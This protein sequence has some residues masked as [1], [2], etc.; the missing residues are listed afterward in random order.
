MKR[1]V[2]VLMAILLGLLADFYSHWWLF[3]LL[4][5]AQWNQAIRYTLS[6]GMVVLVALIVWKLTAGITKERSAMVLKG[7]AIGMFTGF[8]IG[9]IA[10]ILIKP[11][12]PQAVFLGI[13]LTIPLGAVL[14]L[15]GGAL[16]RSGKLRKA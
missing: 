10:P 12:A 4:G 2:R 7:G 11:N 16:Y 6:I 1:E 5:K 9:F 13:F 8:L 14:G 15:I 3:P